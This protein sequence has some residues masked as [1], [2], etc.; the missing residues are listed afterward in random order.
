MAAEIPDE[1]L[2]YERHAIRISKA[3]KEAIENG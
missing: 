3:K 1:F 2:R